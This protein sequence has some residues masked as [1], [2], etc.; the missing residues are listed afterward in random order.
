MFDELFSRIP[1]GIQHKL[2]TTYQ[3]PAHHAEGSVYNHIAL[4][5]QLLPSNNVDFQISAIFH[6]LGKIDCTTFEESDKYGIK[7]KSVGHENL[8][9]TYIKTL[10]NLYLDFNIDWVKVEQ[11]CT[12]HMRAHLYLDGTLS[13]PKKRKALEE[14]AYFSD[15]ITFAQADSEGR[16]TQGG[17]PILII[18]M[19][20]PGSG[21]T[22]WRNSFVS[23]HPDYVVINPDDIRKEVTGNISDQSKNHIV[24]RLAYERLDEA[25]EKKQNVIF[26][27][28]ACSR[29][30]ITEILFH[31]T[32]KSIPCFKVFDVDVETAYGR[33]KKDMENGLDRSNVPY[34]VIVNMRKKFDELLPE[35]KSYGSIIK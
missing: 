18:E 15:I 23:K 12:Q 30:T 24:W 19:G 17:L 14:L 35:I 20:I 7:I 3:S 33:V 26:D 28:T 10:K 29:K 34:D 1:F 5:S 9:P 16:L 13:N 11:I 8:S 27:S 2:R 31:G 21:K 6:D 4:V 22:I 32:R 25:L